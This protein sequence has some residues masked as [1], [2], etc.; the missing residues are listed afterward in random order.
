MAVK[1][2]L[3]LYE[4]AESILQ[5]NVVFTRWRWRKVQRVQYERQARWLKTN[6]KYY[7]VD[8]GLRNALLGS[9]SFDH[10]HDL[11]NMVYLELHRRG[12]QILVGS[13]SNGEVDFIVGRVSLHLLIMRR[14]EPRAT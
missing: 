12:C 1:T 11:E 14:R 9:R 5:K 2:F 7:F 8:P 3:K 13:V 10:G 4:F 6:G